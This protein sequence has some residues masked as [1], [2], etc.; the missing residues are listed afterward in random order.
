MYQTSALSAARVAS[1]DDG[2]IDTERPLSFQAVVS[3][4]ALVI[5]KYG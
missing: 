3:L 4:F 1:T 5:G 2:G